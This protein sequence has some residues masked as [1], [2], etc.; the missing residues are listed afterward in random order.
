MA[1][2]QTP[3]YT[4]EILMGKKIP[5]GNITMPSYI[6]G[7]SFVENQ[8]DTDKYLAGITQCG[9]IRTTE[10]VYDDW[11]VEGK[12]EVNTR[13]CVGA[14]EE[15]TH[16]LFSY[17]QTYHECSGSVSTQFVPTPTHIKHAFNSSEL[18]Y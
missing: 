14:T 10:V 15:N 11:C 9:P 5:T 16:F 7:R 8:E 3:A 6:P 13:S 1:A 12:N 17:K 18:N 4:T 2:F